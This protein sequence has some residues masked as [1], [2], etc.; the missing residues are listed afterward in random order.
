MVNNKQRH[1]EWHNEQHNCLYGR[2]TYQMNQGKVPFT[3]TTF[4]VFGD[5]FHSF[6][7]R[8]YIYW[9]FLWF[10]YTSYRQTTWYSKSRTNPFQFL[11]ENLENILQFF[12]EQV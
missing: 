2:V 6:T 3:I 11:P 8:I 9:H 5:A 12:L 7:E 4:T 1:N 10:A